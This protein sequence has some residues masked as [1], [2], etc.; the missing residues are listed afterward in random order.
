MVTFEAN[1]NNLADDNINIT[2]V[3]EWTRKARNLDVVTGGYANFPGFNEDPSQI[4]FGG[5][6]ERLI[7]VKNKYD[8]K[9]LFPF[10]TNI[11]PRE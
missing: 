9:N 10:N 7:S 8:P 6:Y 2:W 1:W 5:N 3:R 4:V 11:K